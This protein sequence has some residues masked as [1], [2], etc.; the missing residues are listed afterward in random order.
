MDLVLFPGFADE[1]VKNRERL[2]GDATGFVVR[3][4][5]NDFVIDSD[6]PA[7]VRGFPNSVHI[8][9]QPWQLSPDRYAEV[10][11]EYVR[12]FRS[13]EFDGAPQA[14]PKNI[15]I[16]SQYGIKSRLEE[17]KL[18]FFLTRNHVQE[19][20]LVEH[21]FP[22]FHGEWGLDQCFGVKVD[23]V[24]LQ[25]RQ[26]IQ[27]IPLLI[28]EFGPSRAEHMVTRVGALDSMLPKPTEALA[29]LDA[30]IT[31]GNYAIALPVHELGS[32]L[33]FRS[34]GLCQFS[35]LGMENNFEQLT[36]G[37]GPLV[38][39]SSRRQQ[40]L[41]KGLGKRGYDGMIGKAVHA[42]NCML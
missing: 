12:N 26:S 14:P 36:I 10:A 5:G 22:L 17:V 38:V 15:S 39:E 3:K 34:E 32:A 24:R 25:Q 8:T 41:I 35:S 40:F 19:N 23:A 21:V 7:L 37:L 42:V 29:Y 9:P 31:F 1:N 2:I 28:S 27:K 16:D 6:D 18:R 20:S 13:R 33:Y 30:L 4:L 11:R